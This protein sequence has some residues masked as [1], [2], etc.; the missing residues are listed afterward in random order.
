MGAIRE[1]RTG[2]RSFFF[3]FCGIVDV[4]VSYMAHRL[5]G[6]VKPWRCSIEDHHSVRV[7][8]NAIE[9]QRL[10]CL[11]ILRLPLPSAF[12][13]N[14][15]H[16]HDSIPYYLLLYI[17]MKRP[18]PSKTKVGIRTRIHR[19]LEIIVI[20]VIISI[21]PKCTYPTS[22]TPSTPGLSSIFSLIHSPTPNLPPPPS[23]RPDTP[24]PRR[25][26]GDYSA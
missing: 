18:T 17:A 12:D 7:D 24:P 19:A 15:Y 13:G 20:I 11:G 3:F 22:H 6:L 14:D 9:Q 8:Y 21:H 10:K 23:Y 1:K 25:Y 16:E 2:N 4:S 26:P 5:L